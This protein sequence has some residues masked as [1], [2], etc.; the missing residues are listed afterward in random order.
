MAYD[1]GDPNQV[2]QKKRKF[3]L[4]QQL[5]EEE[6]R[7]VLNTRE[8]RA[9]V[10]RV[11]ELCGIFRQSFTGDPAHTYFNEGKRKIG[12]EI[13]SMFEELGPQEGNDLF[14][15]MTSEAMHRQEQLEEHYGG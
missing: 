13:R 10:W 4:D 3:E 14:S 12:L 1:A 9:V 11:L 2:N 8:G 7:H 15:L 5:S 6:F